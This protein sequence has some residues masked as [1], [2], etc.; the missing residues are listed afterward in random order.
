[1]TKAPKRFN[2]DRDVAPWT[3]PMRRYD[4]AKEVT[5]CF[6]VVAVLTVGL[7]VVFSSPDDKAVTL[8]QW[9]SETPVDF[10]TTAIAE[11]DG[12]SGTAGYGGPYNTSSPGQSILGVSPSTIIG[13]HIPVDAAKDFVLSPVA[14]LP[15]DPLAQQALRS[16]RSATPAQRATWDAAYET[17]IA[18]QA[19]SYRDGHLVV[20]LGNYGPVGVIVNALTQMARS[21][22]LD[23]TML[24]EQRFFS[25]DF[26]KPL[27]F[28]S[29]G[30]YLA[31]KAAIDHL[32][33]DQWGMMNETGSWP[34]QAWLWLYTM[35]YQ[36]PGLSTSP[37]ADL[38][39]WAIMMVLTVVLACIPL[40]P[41][42]RSIPR[43]T[44]V[45]RLIWRAHYVAK[46]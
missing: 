18:S 42:L 44:R 5:I 13:V 24:T 31:N 37:N 40:I 3:G 4:I 38:Q 30:N 9:A 21:G 29:D 28:L 1:V 17:A 22:A 10:A 27:L 7:A 45:Y 14:A 39:V 20:P 25:T 15:D 35:W 36:V 11:L 33:G 43:W 26:T 32:Q 46:P 6:L 23:A 2:P 12:T 16:Y 8:Q 41:G 19:A 34:G